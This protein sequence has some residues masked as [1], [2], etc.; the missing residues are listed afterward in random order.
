MGGHLVQVGNVPGAPAGAEEGENGPGGVPLEIGVDEKIA[1][2]AE[3]G[4]NE[5]ELA[6]RPE[7]PDHEGSQ[8]HQPVAGTHGDHVEGGPGPEVAPPGDVPL[9]RSEDRALLGAEKE[10]G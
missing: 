8:A 2:V 10:V 7:A 9:E 5:L 6:H 4:G 3:P 1:I